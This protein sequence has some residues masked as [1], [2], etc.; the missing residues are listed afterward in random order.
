MRMRRPGVWLVTVLAVLA[1]AGCSTP[2]PPT[3]TSSTPASQA[4]AT[5]TPYQGY[6][7]SIA[8]IGHSAI[9]GEGTQSGGSESEWKANSWATGTNAQVN[10]VYLRLRQVNPVVEGHVHNLGQGGA[11]LAA[12]TG[13]ARQLVQIEPQPQLVIIATQ[14]A[15]ST[16]P[17]S[18][19]ELATYKEGLKSLLDMLAAQMPSSRF[20]IT[21][22]ISTPSNDAAIYSAEERA[23]FG[24]TD[25]CAFLDPKG[26]L[27]PAKLHRLEAALAAY[28]S[29]VVAV[30]TK[31]NRCATDQSGAGWR[32]RRSDL[33]D[34]LNH[35][36][37]AG[38][39]RWAEHQWMLLQATQLVPMS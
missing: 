36:N 9:T 18:D 6:P 22:G 35:L 26:R 19:E 27:V 25:A 37:L 3:S 5:G 21:P 13:Q 17:T 34:D 4:S 14:D 29:Q 20:F 2:A 39:R 31:A 33:S 12:L 8:A 38:Q 30:C 15:D 16:C 32:L 24:G 28:R 10:S 23:F 7:D 11:N 1:P